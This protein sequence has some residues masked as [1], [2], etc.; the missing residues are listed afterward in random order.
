M[1]EAKLCHKCSTNK[2]L[3]EF[4]KKKSAKSGL[5]SSCKAC[6]S[7]QN[8]KY[9]STH[10]ERLSI[11]QKTK[12]AATKEKHAERWQAYYSDNADAI[13]R[14][15]NER[16]EQE[17]QEFI[18]LFGGRCE[19]CEETEP[20][21]LTADHVQDDGFVRRE[22]KNQILRLV[23]EKGL[24]EV[25]RRIRILCYSCNSGRN[26]EN[27]IAW[28]GIHFGPQLDTSKTCGTC[29]LDLNVSKFARDKN[30]Q[31][32][33]RRE[34]RKCHS[35]RGKILKEK[36]LEFMGLVCVCCSQSDPH[37]L[38]FD[39]IVG[40]GTRE[41]KAGGKQSFSL[42]RALLSGEIEKS[43]FQTLCH[44]CNFSKHYNGRCIHQIRRDQVPAEGE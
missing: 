17:F 14:V 18:G 16:R 38:T 41:R 29:K 7:K 31:D 9:K 3:S 13:N 22:S 34:C 8:A 43:L 42:Y 21:F 10:K 44:N 28:R 12:Y 19:F 40:G 6:V 39:H 24:E 1:M 2:P 32:G 23:A 5:Y 33:F 30:S 20:E 27:P 36:A 25:K 15:K 37:K 26:A 35:N 4:G 11:V